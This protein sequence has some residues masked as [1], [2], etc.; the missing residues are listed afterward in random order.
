MF[1]NLDN[2]PHLQQLALLPSVNQMNSFY[3]DFLNMEE[4]ATGLMPLIV[5]D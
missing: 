1:K 4:A 5:F 3:L 2:I